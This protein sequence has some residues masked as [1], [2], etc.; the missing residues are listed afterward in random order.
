MTAKIV[1]INP[2][3]TMLKRL[4]VSHRPRVN[5]LNKP[6][7]AA[8]NGPN[9][10]PARAHGTAEKIIIVEPGGSSGKP[11]MGKAEPVE[12]SRPKNKEAIGVAISS[13]AKIHVARAFHSM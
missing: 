2:R 12:N 4:C 9:K 6:S 1:A 8:A 11:G 13:A 10:P 5:P 7:P 3:S